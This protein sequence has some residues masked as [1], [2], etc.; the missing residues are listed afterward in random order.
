MEP[1]LDACT[2]SYLFNA[3][4]KEFLRKA[5][6]VSRIH[7]VLEV[8]VELERSTA[9]GDGFRKLKD[10]LV[11]GGQWVVHELIPGT[12]EQ[13]LFNH[14]RGERGKFSGKDQG[15]LASIAWAFFQ[16]NLVFVTEDQGAVRWAID[17][18]PGFPC[19]VVRTAAWLRALGERGADL[20]A[21]GLGSWAHQVPP[22]L[23]YWWADWMK[24]QG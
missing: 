19:R 17:D 21:K 3:G 2:I 22:P 10:D 9:F 8:V 4:Q 7:T 14:L 13:Q 20:S 11:A 16:T 12:P 18:L 15:E 23:P 5:T 1:L 6:T 24:L